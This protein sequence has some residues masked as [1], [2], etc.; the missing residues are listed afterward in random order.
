MEEEVLRRSP[1]PESTRACSRPAA[2]QFRPAGGP[3]EQASRLVRSCVCYGGRDWLQLLQQPG[4]ET[5]YVS[6]LGQ[7]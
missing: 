2:Q 1:A 6:H 5:L 4:A 7:A 3:S